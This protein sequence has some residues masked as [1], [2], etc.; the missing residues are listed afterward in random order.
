MLQ[1]PSQ[2]ASHGKSAYICGIAPA[3]GSQEVVAHQRLA[4]LGYCF[5]AS[6]PPYLAASA[7]AALRLMR[8]RPDLLPTLWGHARRLRAGVDRIPGKARPCA[9]ASF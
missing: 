1:T 9:S 3:A 4:G 8:Q 5:S 6:L 7:S 2:A